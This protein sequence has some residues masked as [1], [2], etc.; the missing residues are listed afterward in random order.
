MSM[1]RSPVYKVPTPASLCF[2]VSVR[3]NAVKAGMCV[4]VPLGNNLSLVF[5]IKF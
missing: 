3:M 4:C 1:F 5:E 2:S